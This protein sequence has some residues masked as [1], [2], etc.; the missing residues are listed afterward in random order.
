MLDKDGRLIE[1]HGRPEDE[2]AE[3]VNPEV[4]GVPLEPEDPDLDH[5]QGEP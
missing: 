2:H 4:L 3:T 5:L 1:H